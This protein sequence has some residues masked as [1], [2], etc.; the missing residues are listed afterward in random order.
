[1]MIA[2][3]NIIAVLSDQLENIFSY[4]YGVAVARIS[5]VN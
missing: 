2:I 5:M 1:M 4:F 3:P